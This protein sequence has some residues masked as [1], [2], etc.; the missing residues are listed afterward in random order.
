MKVGIEFIQKDKEMESSILT[1]SWW[2]DVKET[3]K[4]ECQYI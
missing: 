3:E 4:L 1:V 2:K